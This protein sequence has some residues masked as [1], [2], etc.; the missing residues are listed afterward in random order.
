MARFRTW[1]R[2]QD[3]PRGA[4]QVQN[5]GPLDDSLNRGLI[6][7]HGP[8]KNRLQLGLTR[9]VDQ[10]LQ[11]EAVK[12]GFRQRVGTLHFQRIL[13]RH[14]EEGI[15]QNMRRVAAGDG[16]FLHGFEKRR[17]RPGG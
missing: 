2:N 3:F 14:H 16:S 13:R 15:F 12:L 9:I 7:G 17:L 4:A 11:Q 1:G 8:L 10:H 6:E 5:L